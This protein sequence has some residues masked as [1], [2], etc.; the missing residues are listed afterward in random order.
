LKRAGILNGA[1]AGALARLGHTDQVLICDSGMPLPRDAE[2]IDLAFLP[3]IPSFA[4]VLE[5]L[6]AELLVEG[7]VAAQEVESGNPEC[8]AFLDDLLPALTYVPH[9]ELKLLAHGVKL[10]VRT[11]E[12][13]PYANVIVRCGVPF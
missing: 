3:G 12:A 7:A 9:D 11:G 1:L 10:V 8:H 6:L 5:G 13:T 4:E 2:V